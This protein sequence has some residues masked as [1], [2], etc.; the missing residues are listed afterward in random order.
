MRFFLG[1]PKFLAPESLQREAVRED[2]GLRKQRERR[3]VV[4]EIVGAQDKANMEISRLP[5]KAAKLLR[6]VAASHSVD[7]KDVAAPDQR[8]R[9]GVE[10]FSAEE[11]DSRCELGGFHA[12]NNTNCR[13]MRKANCFSDFNERFS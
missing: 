9:V 8:R 12:G 6:V 2:L 5:E 11:Q 3:H 1:R 10:T 13:A 7:Q 4:A